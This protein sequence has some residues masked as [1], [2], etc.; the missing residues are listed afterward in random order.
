SAPAGPGVDQDATFAGAFDASDDLGAED[1]SEWFGPRGRYRF[2]EFWRFS[3][4]GFW[5]WLRQ[6]HRHDLVR[7][8][9][10][11]R[12]GRGVRLHGLWLRRVRL[13]RRG[14]VVRRRATGSDGYERR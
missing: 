12:G 4:R 9:P 8:R 5:K 6:D 10:R 1:R 14:R 7:E 11:A 2:V 13:R 3:R